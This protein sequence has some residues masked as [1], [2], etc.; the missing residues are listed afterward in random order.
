MELLHIQLHAYHAI[1]TLAVRHKSPRTE[2][3]VDLGAATSDGL[4]ATSSSAESLQ[5][6]KASLGSNIYNIL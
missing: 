5:G 6:T 2:H 4:I 3:L 1:F